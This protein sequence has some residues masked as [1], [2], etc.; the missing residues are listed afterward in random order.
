MSGKKLVIIGQW[1]FRWELENLV[2]SNN[3]TF[4]GPQYWDA[5]VSLV[6]NSSWLVFPGEEDFWIVPIEVMAA[7]KPVFAYKWWWLTETVLE[8]TTWEFFENKEWK[9]FVEKF[10]IFDK[11][12]WKKKYKKDVCIKQAENFSIEVFEKKIKKLINK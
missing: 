11:N 6:Q 8:W 1:N 5:L 12:N 2:E 10:K 7:G 9:D 3:I 4:T